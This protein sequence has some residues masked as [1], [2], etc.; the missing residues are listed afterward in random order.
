MYGVS[1]K[2]EKAFHGHG[3]FMQSEHQHVDL[4][5]LFGLCC[6]ELVNYLTELFLLL[7]I[8]ILL[9]FMVTG[10][11]GHGSVVDATG[12]SNKF[13][14]GM[15]IFDDDTFDYTEFDWIKFEN[16]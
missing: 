1:S 10:F 7:D 13:D 2:H 8:F 16:K 12:D 4:L 15:N 11:H 9:D 3:L 5:Q 14:N 6:N